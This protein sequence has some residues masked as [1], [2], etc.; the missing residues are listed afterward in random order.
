MLKAGS[1]SVAELERPGHP[2][3]DV[4]SGLQRQSKPEADAKPNRKG[5]IFRLRHG[6]QLEIRQT[7]WDTAMEDGFVT[8]LPQHDCGLSMT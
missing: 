1:D 8:T 6:V 5:A 2:A 4:P 7:W 3:G